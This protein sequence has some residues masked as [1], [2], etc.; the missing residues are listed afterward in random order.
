MARPYVTINNPNQIAKLR[1]HLDQHLPQFAAL[2]GVIGITLNGGMSRGY[3]DD[4]SE[5]DVTFFLTPEAYQHWQSGHAP[6]G[7]GIQVIDGALYD[8][9]PLDLNAER[10]R[11]WEMVTRWDASYAEILHDPEG[12]V[13]ALYA[14]KLATRPEPTSAGGSLFSAWWHFRLAGDIWLHRGDA[15]Q[16]HMMLH[17]A[18]IELIK[19][20]FLANAEYVPHDK[21]LIHMSRSLAW[22]P[23]GWQQRLTHALCTVGPDAGSLRTR[24][25]IIAALWDEIEAHIRAEHAPDLPVNLTQQWFY[26]KLAWLAE[27]GT[28]PLDEWS[29]EVGLSVL[30]MDPFYPVVRVDNDAVTLD[31]DKL[32]TLPLESMYAWHYAILAAVAARL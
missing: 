30:S 6:F 13:A 17:Q 31:R 22:T 20:L 14:E 26:D 28:I 8:L 11:D 29:A 4:L 9:K 24:Q 32:R 23:D 15:L 16:G 2:P 1:A 25:Q 27:K 10:A 7:T 18:V 19:A 12:Q 21:W 3:A 5:I